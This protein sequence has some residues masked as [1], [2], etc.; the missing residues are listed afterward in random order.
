MRD[1]A[2]KK[3][4]GCCGTVAASPAQIAYLVF[5]LHHE[6]CL[7][8]CVLGFDVIHQRCEGAAICFQCLLSQGGEYFQFVAFSRDCSWKA[9]G[10]LFDPSRSVVGESVLPRSKPEQDEMH[11]LL[12]S[13]IDPVVENL[14]V[15]MAFCRLCLLPGDGH[16]DGVDVQFGQARE[17]GVCL[18]CCPGR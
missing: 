3:L 11:L 8:V 6:N 10:V 17:N 1:W 9:S 5:H 7:L 15:K 4:V 14:K 12:T 16:Q 13:Y 18:C 2:L